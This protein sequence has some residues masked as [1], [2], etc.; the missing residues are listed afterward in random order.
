MGEDLPFLPSRPG[1]WYWA[2][3]GFLLALGV[4]GP[5]MVRQ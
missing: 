4:P 5:L 2:A 1:L 3:W